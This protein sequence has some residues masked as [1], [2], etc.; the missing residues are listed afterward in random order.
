MKIG[1]LHQEDLKALA[2]SVMDKCSGKEKINYI[3]EQIDK[4]LEHCSKRAKYYKK[5]KDWSNVS[6]YVHYSFVYL[7]VR[8]WLDEKNK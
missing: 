5:L 3:K 1:E 2:E 8:S 4:E 6:K 7:Q